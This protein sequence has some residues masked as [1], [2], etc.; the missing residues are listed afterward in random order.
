MQKTS[1]PWRLNIKQ[2]S[3]RGESKHGPRQSAWAKFVIFYLDRQSS[4]PENIR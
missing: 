3:F 2:A 1:E 4:W